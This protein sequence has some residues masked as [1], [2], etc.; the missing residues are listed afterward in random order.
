MI[1]TFKNLLEEKRNQVQ[2][3]KYKYE[4]GHQKIISTEATVGDMQE[5]LIQ[6]QPKLKIA[7]EETAKKVEEVAVEKEAAD[8]LKEEI[9]K[10]EAIV[11]V[12]VDEV[13][14]IHLFII[15]FIY[16]IYFIYFKIYLF[17]LFILKFI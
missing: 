5:N 10:E 7:A 12:A 13:F 6:L 14:I 17:L 1:V 11:Q 2:G 4:N 16:F 3:N 8:K 15:K 9:S